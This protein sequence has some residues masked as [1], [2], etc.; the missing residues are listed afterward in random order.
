M[1]ASTWPDGADVAIA[2]PI[3][4]SITDVVKSRFSNDFSNL[5]IVAVIFSRFIDFIAASSCLNNNFRD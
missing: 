2:S 1:R 3:D 5:S 4:P